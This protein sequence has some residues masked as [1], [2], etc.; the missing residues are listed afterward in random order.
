MSV[1]ALTWFL[2]GGIVVSVCIA[3][4]KTLE[5]AMIRGIPSLLRGVATFV[6]VWGMLAIIVYLDYQEKMAP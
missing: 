4:A 1:T 3:W 2:W 6:L 5:W